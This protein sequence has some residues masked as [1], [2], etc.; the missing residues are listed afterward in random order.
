MD[1][2]DR[3]WP[4]R[5]NYKRYGLKCRF[6]WLGRKADAQQLFET[7]SRLQTRRTARQVGGIAIMM[8]EYASRMSSFDDTMNRIDDRLQNVV[9]VRRVD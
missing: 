5:V 7:L 9:G 6:K 2:D 4:Q 1:D 8:H 3:F